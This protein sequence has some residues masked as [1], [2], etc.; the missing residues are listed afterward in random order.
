MKTKIISVQ[1][2]G[3]DD[4]YNLHLRLNGKSQNLPLSN[5]LGD[6]LISMGDFEKVENK[7]VPVRKNSRGN[8]VNRMEDFVYDE[9]SRKYLVRQ[10]E[11]WIWFVT[12]GTEREDYA[13]S[14]DYLDL[15]FFLW[16]FKDVLHPK[17][18]IT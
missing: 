11:K 8:I 4:G 13:G 5:Q 15:L 6:Q 16:R 18:A 1:K 12:F 9:Y 7:F 17:R 10:L 14:D 2:T 3:S